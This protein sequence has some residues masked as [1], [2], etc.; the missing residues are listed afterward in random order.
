MA[1]DGTAVRKFGE[2]SLTEFDSIV[3]E[4]EARGPGFA[5]R[6]FSE[7]IEQPAGGKDDAV[8]KEA[9][10]YAARRNKKAG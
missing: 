8:A 9:A 7:Q 4:V 10:D 6:H 5:R 2:Q 1:A 3:A